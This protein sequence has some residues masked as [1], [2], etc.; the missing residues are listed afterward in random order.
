MS[1]S[2]DWPD[3]PD[4]PST[5][6]GPVRAEDLLK[7]LDRVVDTHLPTPSAAE[8]WTEL[9]GWMAQEELS[10]QRRDDWSPWPVPVGVSPV[11]DPVRGLPERKRYAERASADAPEAETAELPATVLVEVPGMSV[12]GGNDAVALHGRL[13]VSVAAAARTALHAAVDDG[14]GDLVLDLRDLGSW[15]ATGLGVIMGAHR[16]AGRCGRRLVL[17]DVPPQMHRLLTH[18]RLDR[19]LTMENS[20]ADPASHLR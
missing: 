10:E 14:A 3:A 4:S 7:R 16:R 17:R 11:N 8:G 2:R 9:Q 12:T 5:A 13:D 19:I 1:N 18:T 15:D 6:G 20:V